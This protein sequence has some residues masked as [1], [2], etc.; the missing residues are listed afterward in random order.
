MNTKDSMNKYGLLGRNNNQMTILLNRIERQLGLSV[1]PLPDGL[2]KDDWAGIIMEDTIPVFS[3]YFP[4]KLCE[5]ITPDM[6]KG[7]WCYIDQN[8]P[9]GTRI[10]GVKD[11]DWNAYKSDWTYDKYGIN[12]L[13]QDYMASREFILDDVALTAA[14]ADLVSLF[15]LGIYIEFEMPNKIKLVTVNGAPVSQFRPFPLIILIEHPGLYTISPTMMEQ[16]TK[17][18]KSDVALAIYNV[19]KYYDD[20]DSAYGS[21]QLKLD[22]LQDWA[23]RR[24]DI[25][26][27]LDEA[28]NTTANENAPM[29]MTV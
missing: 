5:I 29:I 4:Y 13:S 12:T 2:K 11:L 3:Q 14:G 16:F 1:M 27:E 20:F 7:E 15:D 8:L 26:R 6:K 18:A 22:V 28:H 19:L 17:L 23:N 24:D 9:E 10:L 21:L 25:I